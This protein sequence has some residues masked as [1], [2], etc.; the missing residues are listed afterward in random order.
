MQLFFQMA[1]HKIQ[2]SGGALTLTLKPTPKCL[3]LLKSEWCPQALRISF[4]LETDN[5]ILMK[6]VRATIISVGASEL[7]PNVS[8]DWCV[9]DALVMKKGSIIITSFLA[10][11]LHPNVSIGLVRGCI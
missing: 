9:D 7:H 5:A 1:E 6:K 8:T 2:S 10:S 3:G 4:K 11:G